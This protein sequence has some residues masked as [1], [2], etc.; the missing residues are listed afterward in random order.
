[1]CSSGCPETN[2]VEDLESAVEIYWNMPGFKD[3]SYEERLDGRIVFSEMQEDL[4]EH[5]KL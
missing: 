4:I 2:D 5:I 3:I 1:M